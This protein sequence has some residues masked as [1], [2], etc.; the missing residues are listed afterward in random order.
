[1][2]LIIIFDVVI[3]DYFFLSYKVQKPIDGGYVI[4]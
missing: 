4:T 3:F 1:M 2:L